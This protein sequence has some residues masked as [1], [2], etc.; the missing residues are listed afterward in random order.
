MVRTE[1]NV[2]IEISTYWGDKEYCHRKACVMKNSNGYYVDMWDHDQL[3]E[4]RTLYKHSEIYAQNA[5]EN[6]VLGIMKP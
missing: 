4:S 1:N 5:A 2:K 6:Y 3:V